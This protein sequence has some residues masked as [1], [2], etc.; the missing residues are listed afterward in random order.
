MKTQQLTSVGEAAQKFSKLFYENYDK[1][2]NKLKGFYL[3]NAQLVWNG[4]AVSGVDAILP[5]LNG[6]PSSATELVCLD[7]Q[8]RGRRQGA[9]KASTSGRNTHPF[10]LVQCSEVRA[11]NFVGRTI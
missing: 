10:Q 3:E 7:A 8:V 5:F 6:L 11:W 9:L 1:D 4:N 2:R